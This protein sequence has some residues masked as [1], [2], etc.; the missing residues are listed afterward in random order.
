MS[1]DTL[2]V[3]LDDKVFKLEEFNFTFGEILT[4]QKKAEISNTKG[5]EYHKRHETFWT[6]NELLKKNGFN[7]DISWLKDV[8]ISDM[9]HVLKKIKENNKGFQ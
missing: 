9:Q 5:K 2:I 3:E 4:A 7:V 8:P 1:E 6:V